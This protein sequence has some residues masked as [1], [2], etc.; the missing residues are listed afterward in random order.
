MERSSKYSVI[1]TSCTVIN[2][3]GE[4]LVEKSVISNINLGLNQKHLY[5][6][7]DVYI[8]QIIAA[9]INLPEIKSYQ[10]F[11]DHIKFFCKFAGSNILEVFQLKELIEGTG[12]NYLK[13]VVKELK[14]AVDS[15]I[16]LDPHIKNFVIGEE[17][18]FYVDFS[19]PYTKEYIKMRLERSAS[20]EFEIIRKNFD[21]FK[22]ENLM[23]H[24]LG[25]FFNI[26]QNIS[27]ELLE[28]IYAIINEICPQDQNFTKFIQKSK[29]IRA[30]EDERI[31]RNIYLY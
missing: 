5:E 22:P 23:H 26:D 2:F 27:R 11:D 1:G 13:M 18:L 15:K 20:S 19:P 28:G 10:L 6:Y 29:K 7:F 31:Q 25:D 16:N 30:L 21:Y 3:E 9:G 12:K 14:K 8:N 4:S 17:G 24:F